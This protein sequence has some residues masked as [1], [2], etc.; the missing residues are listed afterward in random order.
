MRSD[1]TVRMVFPWSRELSYTAFNRKKEVHRH[2][3]IEELLIAS[4]LYFSQGTFSARAQV[5]HRCSEALTDDGLTLATLY[6][7]TPA[8]ADPA[9]KTLACRAAWE[10]AC[11][12]SALAHTV[13]PN[14]LAYETKADAEADFRQWQAN[15]RALGRQYPHRI[16]LYCQLLSKVAGALTGDRS[17]DG[18]TAYDL[19]E[20]SIRLERPGNHCI[21]AMLASVPVQ[22]SN[23]IN[24]GYARACQHTIRKCQADLDPPR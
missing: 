17:I 20:F 10:L 3:L 8:Y 13:Q 7:I 1:F 14:S 19:V 16:R 5:Q 2:R 9:C 22:A 18:R 15:I 11:A 24:L 12:T 23:D 6:A 21:R 4:L